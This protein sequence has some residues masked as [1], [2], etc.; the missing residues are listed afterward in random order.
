MPLLYVDDGLLRG[1]QTED[2]D[3]A[4]WGVVCV[5]VA[6]LCWL[7]LS[8][9]KGRNESIKEGKQK[10]CERVPEGGVHG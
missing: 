6:V 8:K 10:L 9:Q 4:G 1:W 5:G 7:E 2:D 3:V